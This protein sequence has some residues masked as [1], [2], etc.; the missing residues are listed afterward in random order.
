VKTI[1]LAKPVT[2]DDGTFNSAVSE[3][4][5]TGGQIL[6]GQF[7]DF[8]ISAD[9]LPTGISQL[10]FKAIQTYSNGDVVRWIDL[11]Q[12]G[13]PGPD[14]PAPTL[15]L[16]TTTAPASTVRTSAAPAAT[17]SGTDGLSRALGVAGLLVG[18]LACLLALMV[19]RQ[20]RRLAAGDGLR[21]GAPAAAD[22]AEPAGEQASDRVLAGAEAAGRRDQPP[23]GSK[24]SAQR[25]APANPK[26][27]SRQPQRRRRG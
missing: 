12:P 19:A 15:T 2:T 26:A 25:K 8:S 3:V 17:A 1:T 7:Q 6:P 4:T 16:T 27:S 20:S 14:H 5:W 9:P 11:Q 23:A 21:A 24:A 22:R 13:Q 18:L 10:V